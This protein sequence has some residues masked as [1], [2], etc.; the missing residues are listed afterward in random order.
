MTLFT[1]LDRSAVTSG[2]DSRGGLP[3]GPSVQYLL[4]VQKATAHCPT[5]KCTK[6]RPA[7]ELLLLL[8]LLPTLLLLLRLMLQWYYKFQKM[9]TYSRIRQT[10]PP[11]SPPGELTKH[12]RRL[13]LWPIPELYENMTS[14]TKPEVLNTL[15][16]RQRTT[17][18]RP[19][20]TCTENLTKF[21]HAFSEIH[22]RTDRQTYKQVDTSGPGAKQNKTFFCFEAGL[23]RMAVDICVRGMIFIIFKYLR[24]PK[25]GL[26]SEASIR[27]HNARMSCAAT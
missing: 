16:C 9:T 27:A 13:W 8:L 26:H 10:S 20:V 25:V 11:V 19:Q 12:T 24:A 14:S 2:T 15:H 4:V 18:P 3:M 1:G 17:E 21:R 5:T 7:F 6:P 22:T 23:L